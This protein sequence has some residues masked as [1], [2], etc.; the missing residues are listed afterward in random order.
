MYHLDMSI[1]AFEKLADTKLGVIGVQWR[2]VPC[3]QRPTKAARVPGNRQ[4]TPGQ[5]PQHL[6][7]NNWSKSMDKRPRAYLE[8]GHRKALL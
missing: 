7:I 3:W 2:D 4:P 1:W 5:T 6:G 8:Y